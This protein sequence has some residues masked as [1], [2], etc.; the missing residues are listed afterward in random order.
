MPTQEEH[1]FTGKLA[2]PT[3][4]GQFAG[5]SLLQGGGRHTAG[6]IQI[7]LSCQ[8]KWACEDSR[9]GQLLQWEGLHG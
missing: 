4:A 6:E 8:A 5:L 2:I 3:S 1:N 7:E 9:R